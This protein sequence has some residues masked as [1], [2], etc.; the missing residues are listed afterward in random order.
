MSV[1][2]PI[3][4]ARERGGNLAVREQNCPRI[5]PS[6]PELY[7]IFSISLVQRHRFLH[8]TVRSILSSMDLGL[9]GFFSRKRSRALE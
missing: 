4:F 5:F 6:L 3:S 8:R 7:T 9:F 2:V 1:A